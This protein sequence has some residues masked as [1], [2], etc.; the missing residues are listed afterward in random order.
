MKTATVLLL[1][2][3]YA[4]TGRAVEHPEHRITADQARALVMASLAGEQR[5]LPKLG[6]EQYDAPESSQFLFFTAISEGTPNGS[7]VV[8]NYAVDPYTGDVWSAVIGCHE[9]KNK[10]LRALQARMRSTLHLSQSEY[11]RLKTKGPLCGPKER[12][13]RRAVLRRPQFCLKL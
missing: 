9:E 4:T 2:S 7:V 5:R 11:Q 8:G 12:I 10:R 13:S 6:A 3:L 1:V